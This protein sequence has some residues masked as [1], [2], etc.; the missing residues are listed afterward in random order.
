MILDIREGQWKKQRKGDY[1]TWK[2]WD[3]CIDKGLTSLS[4]CET[5]D[6]SLFSGIKLIQFEDD[7][8][9]NGFFATNVSSSRR[10]D[11]ALTFR[12]KRGVLI[13]FDKNMKLPGI[14]E[15]S[16]LCADVS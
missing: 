15:G 4:M 7:P 12:G 2:F 10:E 5:F 16:Q 13:K 1:I 6:S 8:I 11:V 9:E 3:F 14:C